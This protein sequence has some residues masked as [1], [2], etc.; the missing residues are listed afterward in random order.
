MSFTVSADLQM[1]VTFGII[2][3]ALAAYVA[4]KWPMVL[5]SLGTICAILVFFQ[6]FQ[7]EGVDPLRTEGV[8]PSRILQGFANTALIAVLSLLVMGRG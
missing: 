5:T 8:S 1:W 2:L 3:L 7:V 4:E 6:F